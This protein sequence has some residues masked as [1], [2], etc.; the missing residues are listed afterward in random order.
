MKINFKGETGQVEFLSNTECIE[1]F[2]SIWTGETFVYGWGA[3]QYA[4]P[5]LWR[6]PLPYTAIFDQN[7]SYHGQFWNGCPILDPKE[8]LPLTPQQ[9]LIVILP[10]GPISLIED[11][12]NEIMSLGPYKIV[13]SNDLQD[14]QYLFPHNKCQTHNG[15]IL[16]SFSAL[17]SKFPTIVPKVESA[18][19]FSN[20]FKKIAPLSLEGVLTYLPFRE[21]RLM[22]QEQPERKITLVIGSLETGGAEAQ[23]VALAIALKKQRYDVIILTYYPQIKKEHQ[24]NLDANHIEVTCLNTREILRDATNFEQIIRDADIDLRLLLW[25]LPIDASANF[26]AS[27][28]FFNQEKPDIVICYLDAPSIASGL[29][30][31]I[32]GVPRIALSGRNYPPN[33]LPH[34]FTDQM[35]RDFQSIYQIMMN[36]EQVCLYTNSVQTSVSYASWLSLEPE[37]VST[38]ENCLSDYFAMQLAQT[39]G[40]CIR[41]RLGLKEGDI[42]VLGA[43]RLSEEKQPFLF[44]DIVAELVLQIDNLKIALCGNGLLFNAIQE[45]AKQAGL[46]EDVFFMLGDCDNMAEWMKAA[47]LLLHTAQVEGMPNVLIEAQAAGL[48]VISTNAGA[49]PDILSERLKPFLCNVGE[50]DHLIEACLTL[51]S[52]KTRKHWMQKVSTEIYERFSSEKLAQKTLEIVG[53]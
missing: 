4:A 26:F 38:I 53:V 2:N 44:I 33:Q 6:F 22:R 3:S 10:I 17:L 49:I 52:D 48:P 12:S 1:F 23:I 45:S 15:C 40:A 43:F 36:Y 8:N 30:A 9:C 11:I 37:K 29:A 5:L 31:L 16:S 25:L 41:E 50:K 51:L 19:S 47:D 42:L 46:P 14:W 7:S 32:S 34:F 27:L 28:Q 18:L 39:T 13:S 35:I 24:L 20:S 21:K